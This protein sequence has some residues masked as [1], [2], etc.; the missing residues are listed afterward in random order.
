MLFR[1]KKKRKKKANFAD[2][3]DE[4]GAYYTHLEEYE[5]KDKPR[6]RICGNC[7]KH[8]CGDLRCIRC[9]QPYCSR[10][11]AKFAEF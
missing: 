2:F 10:K 11:S 9:D 1:S 4:Y 6:V 7:S 3:N 5:I 8:L